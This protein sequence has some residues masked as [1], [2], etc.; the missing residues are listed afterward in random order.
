[1]IKENLE[2]ENKRPVGKNIY[3]EIELLSI[4]RPETG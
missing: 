3:G 1:M 4:Q 2:T